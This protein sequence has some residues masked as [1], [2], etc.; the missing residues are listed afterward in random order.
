MSL[1]LKDWK[2]VYRSHLYWIGSGMIAFV[3]LLIL[4]QV[5]HLQGDIRF[6]AAL[7]PL[8]RINLYFVPF[9]ALIVSSM[10]VLQEKSQ[11][12]LFVLLSSHFSPLRFLLEKS[13]SIHLILF[14]MILSSYFLVLLISRLFLQADFLPFLAFLL[15]ILALSAVFAQ[16]GI[17]VGV[18][19]NHKMAAFAVCL[20]IWAGFLYVYDLVLIYVIPGIGTD[21]LFFFSLFYFF[22]PVHAIEYFLSV[23]LGFYPLDRNSA[24]FNQVLFRSPRLV[25]AANFLFW[26]GVS[27]IISH[28]VLKR[29]G[30]RE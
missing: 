14:S 6:S 28:L 18:A 8:F 9:M 2:E 19:M 25:L 23:Q 27:I 11:R 10:L 15:S 16:I 12:T 5:T 21:E 20:L 24:I 30:I 17:C 29:K 22:S 26:A 3:S 4:W 7:M 13:I 1:L